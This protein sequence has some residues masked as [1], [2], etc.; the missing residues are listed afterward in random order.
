M[1]PRM[2]LGIVYVLV[3]FFLYA[4]ALAGPALH[5]VLVSMPPGPEQEAMAEEVAREAVR[6]RLGIALVASLLTVAGAGYAKLLPG[7]RRG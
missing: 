6:G 3:F 2:T 7:I 1:Q 4:L 5:Q